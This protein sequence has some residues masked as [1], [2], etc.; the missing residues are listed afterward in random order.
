MGNC[1]YPR[2]LKK[3]KTKMQALGIIMHKILRIIYGMLKSNTLY[4]PEIDRANRTKTV[5]R[6][7]THIICKN[8]RFQAH[9]HQAP[10]S[11]KQNKKR[12]EQMKS[13]NDNIIKNGII[14]SAHSK[15]SKL[16]E[17]VPVK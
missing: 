11:R 14:T 3:G 5:E 6:A 2:H 16:F 8:R 7:V 15:D 12:E 1:V 9:D 10:V 17:K 4:D 13:Q